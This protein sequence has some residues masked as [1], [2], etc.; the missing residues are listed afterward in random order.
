M[1]IL[2]ISPVSRAS[3]RKPPARSRT[4]RRAIWPASRPNSRK[5]RTELGV[6]D[7]L[8][9]GRPASPPQMMAKLGENDVKSLEDF[10]GCV[11]D[12]L[13]GWSERKDGETVKTPGYLRGL[14]LSTRPRQRP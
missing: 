10:A 12:D 9:R 7:D 2:P 14:R 13:I 8:R 3:T 1:S 6:S 4:V 11:G 5:R